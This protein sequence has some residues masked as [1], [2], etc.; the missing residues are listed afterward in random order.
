MR[1]PAIAL[2]GAQTDSSIQAGC[3][4][5]KPGLSPTNTGRNLRSPGPF[6][7]GPI[8]LT[9]WTS[10]S[11][12][13]FLGTLAVTESHGLIAKKN[14]PRLPRPSASSRHVARH[15]GLGDAE[16]EHQKFTMDPRRTP[17]KVLTGHP[18][19]QMVNFTGNLRAP[20]PPPPP[21]SISPKR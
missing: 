15:G 13:P 7:L 17:E 18:Y 2:T 6:E 11:P 21:C 16:T 20:A 4:R 14:P 1:H 8:G 19:D 5:P 3:G 12:G 9:L 10:V